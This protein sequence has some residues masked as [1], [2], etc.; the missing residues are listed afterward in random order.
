MTYSFGQRERVY[1]NDELLG[2]R[3][4]RQVVAALSVP[5]GGGT[6]WIVAALDWRR[7]ASSAAALCRRILV[8]AGLDAEAIK[9]NPTRMT[10][11]VPIARHFTPISQHYQNEDVP[12]EEI[13]PSLG[14]GE[15]KRWDTLLDEFRVVILADA[16]AGKTHELRTIAAKLIDEGKSAFFVRLEDIDAAFG[17]AFEIGTAQAFEAWVRGT[18]EAWFFLDS[19][20]ELR[21]SE[22]RAFEAAIRAFAARVQGA[23]QRAHIYITSRPYAWRTSLDRALVSDILPHQLLAEQLLGSDGEDDDFVSN[24][25]AVGAVER[26]AVP[27]EERDAEGNVSGGEDGGDNGDGSSGSEKSALS[28]YLLA[29]LSDDDIRL[30]AGASG[31]ADL[32]AFLAALEHRN[33]FPLARIPFDLRDLIDAWR[34]NGALGKR[35]DVLRDSVRRLLASIGPDSS[36]H[37]AALEA[38]QLLAIAT[39]LTGLSNIRLPG[40]GSAHALDATEL[41][42]QW[43][44]PC[45]DRVLASGVFGDPIFGEVRFRHRE[46]R[47]LLAAEWAYAQFARATGRDE[48]ERLIYAAPYGVETLR[49]RLRPLLPWLILFDA[50]VRERVLRGQP[51][52]ALE[53]G[54][55][56]SLDLAPREALLATLMQQVVD[57]LSLSRGLDNAAIARIAQSDLEA[58][59]LT[60]IERYRDHDDAIF[61]L[62]RLAWQGELALC[63]PPLI[64]IAADPARG[65]YARLVSVRAVATIGS[66]EQIYALWAAVNADTSPIPRRLLAEFAEH[67][68]V[69]AE[70]VTLL[71]TSIELLEPRQEFEASGLT[72]AINHFVERAIIDGDDPSGG[73][74]TALAEGLQLLFDRPPYVKRGECHVSEEFQWLMGPALLIVERMILA[75][76]PAALADAALSILAAVPALRFWHSSDYQE[77]KSS[78]DTLVPAWI[79]LNDALFW[80][81]VAGYRAAKS[82]T[83]GQLTD[84]WPITY[85][86]HFWSFDGPSFSRTLAWV[87]ARDLADDRSVALARSFT[88]YMQSDRPE[89]WLADMRAAVAGDSELEALLQLKLDP[90]ETEI[91]REHKAWE[92]K[93]NRESAKRKRREA[94]DRAVFI[95][96]VTADPARVRKPPGV[97]RGQFARI[98]YNLLRIVEGEGLRESRVQ[99]AD[100]PALIPEFGQPVAEAYRDAAMAY[101]RGYKPGLRS[102]GADTNQIPYALIFAMAGLDIE[103]SAAGA[104]AALT[105]AHARRAFRYVTW[106]LNGF[107]RW[108]ETLYR[109]K[110]NLGFEFLWKEIAWELENTPAAEVLNYILSDLVYYAPWLQADVAP[111]LLE[112]LEDNHPPSVGTLRYLRTIIMSGKCGNEYAMATLARAKL[113]DAT[114]PGDQL[115]T[116]YAMWVDSEPSVAIADLDALLGGG[117]L[118]DPLLFAMVFVTALMGGRSDTGPTRNFGNFKTPT[119]LKH[120]YLLMHRE[121]PVA[122]DLHRAGKGVY[123]PNL[124]DDAQ[125]ARE[126]LFQLLNETSGSI[127]Y[128]AIRELAQVHPVIRYRESMAAHANAHAVVDGDLAIWTQDEVAALARRILATSQLTGGTGAAN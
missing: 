65:I 68:V 74:L 126:R 78:V 77:R 95:A 43:N 107:P 69:D 104:A 128:D 4:V 5:C 86:G 115:P 71:L 111:P 23:L 94:R 75:R 11:A 100:W 89:A 101:W 27:A 117:T 50:N 51:E 119:Y 121:I 31:I 122:D 61:V 54:D 80:R 120:L 58:F 55:A 105:P 9:S 103:L 73:D 67:A 87:T 82:A 123:S 2:P 14:R 32:D 56:A 35:L 39:S 18:R 16:G 30:F 17:D 79:A 52:V 102:E 62:A 6:D 34:T 42:D 90:P 64:T 28:V 66:A 24:D 3:I 47:D 15:R 81:T 57:P 76:S 59:V 21:L 85:I 41:L 10:D 124:R 109:A 60:L 29:P 106:E 12:L 110:P 22:P 19:V 127:A 8:L 48:I 46:V 26:A 20:D 38:V 125:D 33:L 72:Y 112:W 114:T 113:A 92:R 36:E 116:W 7:L 96:E 37:D 98:H 44:D 49:P 93:H 83:G 25:G 84:D 88:T 91:G 53:G 40:L 99:G 45:I 13:W 108:F 1:V 70:T 97:K 118:N 63:L